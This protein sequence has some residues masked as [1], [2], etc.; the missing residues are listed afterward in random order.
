MSNDKKFLIGIL[1]IL[2]VVVGGKLADNITRRIY[3]YK[4]V[5]EFSKNMEIINGTPVLGIT[6]EEVVEE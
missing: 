2:G 4:V 1:S 6:N 3:N 5:K